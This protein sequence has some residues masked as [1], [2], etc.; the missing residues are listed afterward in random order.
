RELLKENQSLLSRVTKLEE[1]LSRLAVGVTQPPSRVQA[2]FEV[3]DGA[4][5]SLFMVTGD[6]GSGLGKNSRVRIGRASG[7]NFLLTFRNGTGGI[8]TAVGE[9]KTGDGGVSL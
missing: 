1:N 9:A 3:V 2:P 6:H 4:G 8:V 7:D 5:N